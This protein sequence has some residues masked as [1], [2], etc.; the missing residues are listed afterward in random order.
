MNK[1]NTSRYTYTT[2]ANDVLALLNGEIEVT[3]ALRERMTEKANALL[4]AQANK[5]AYNAAHPKKGTAK[6]AS[7]ETKAK[8]EAIKSVLG[9]EPMTA[10][11]INAALG[12]DYTALQVANAVKFI[13]GVKTSKVVRSTVNGKGLKAEKEYTAYSIG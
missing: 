1:T 8:A 6:G 3:D 2:F 7:A 9:A 11:E 12:A 10:A 13:E 4:T 5:A